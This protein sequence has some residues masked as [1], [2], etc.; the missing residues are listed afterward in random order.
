MDRTELVHG[1]DGMWTSNGV[2]FS[3]GNRHARASLPT[4]LHR[5]TMLHRDMDH[6][7]AENPMIS[8]TSLVEDI[9]LLILYRSFNDTPLIPWLIPPSGSHNGSSRCTCE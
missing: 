3:A 7:R 4:S 1:N 6:L 9:G 2:S 8:N 5:F